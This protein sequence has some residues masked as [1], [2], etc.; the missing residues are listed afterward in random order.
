MMPFQGVDAVHGRAEAGFQQDAVQS[1]PVGGRGAR[2]FVR[3]GENFKGFMDDI[4]VWSDVRTPAEISAFKDAD[5]RDVQEEANLLALFTLDDGGWPAQQVKASVLGRLAAPPPNPV[6]GQRYLI[7][8][9]AIGDWS[10][11]ENWIAQFGTT[12]WLFTEP[13]VGDILLNEANAARLQ[14]DGADWVAADTVSILRGVDYNA[15]PVD[16]LKVDGASW[17]DGGGDIVVMD[18]GAPFVTPWGDPVFCEGAVYGGAAAADDFAWWASRNKY[19]RFVGGDWMAWGRSL[20]WL[21]PVRARLA[22]D[23]NVVPDVLSL[24]SDAY[25]GAKYIVTDATDFGLYI[26]DGNGGYAKDVLLPEDRFLVGDKIQ[27]WDGTAMVTLSDAEISQAR[28]FICWCGMKVLLMARQHGIWSRWGALPLWKITRHERTGTTNGSW[29]R[30]FKAMGSSVCWM[31][32]R[33]RRATAMATDFPMTGKSRMG[34]ILRP[35]RRTE[36]TAIRMPTA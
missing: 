20:Y 6:S 19:Y 16:E 23:A 34:L 12:T 27:V 3:A 8:A 32:R 17:L 7:G 14:Y 25:T 11:R 18:S 26:M 5:V 30:K 35:I 4:R 36:P 9:P 31:A 33:L 24:P 28:C 29:R 13:Q 1:P 10:G 2:S 15:E 22:G 21:D